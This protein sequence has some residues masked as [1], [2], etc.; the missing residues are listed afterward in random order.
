[1]RDSLGID[2]VPEHI[3][4][5]YRIRSVGALHARQCGVRSLA[6][7]YRAAETGSDGFERARSFA[8]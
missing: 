4:S 5:R 3:E 1:V 8:P 2:V 6:F 7:G